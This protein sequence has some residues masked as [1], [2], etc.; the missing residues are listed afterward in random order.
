MVSRSTLIP[1]APKSGRRSSR[2]RVLLMALLLVVAAFALGSCSLFDFF[3]SLE[4]KIGGVKVTSYAFSL[5]NQD[6]DSVT[7]TLVNTGIFP[8]NLGGISAI[9][10]TGTNAA[11][12][13]VSGSPG[14][15]IP[16]GGST[17][18][19]VNFDDLSNYNQTL[20]ATVKITPA[21]NA[22]DVE[23]TV[24]GYVTLT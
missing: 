11:N 16:A 15:E 21:G 14:D 20:R 13:S 24:T 2:K 3:D 1:Q 17:T 19:T 5:V 9:T 23:L 22:P 10:V 8:L 7:V 6:T 18:F 4:V 12:F